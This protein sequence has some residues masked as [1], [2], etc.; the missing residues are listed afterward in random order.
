MHFQFRYERTVK[1][2]VAYYLTF[3]PMDHS[4]S[5]LFF[6]TSFEFEVGS[7]LQ[8]KRT[9]ASYNKANQISVQGYKYHRRNIEHLYASAT[10]ITDIDKHYGTFRIHKYNSA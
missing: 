3:R 10:K 6:S 9:V 1:C 7:V 5:V 8:I 2:L 4:Q